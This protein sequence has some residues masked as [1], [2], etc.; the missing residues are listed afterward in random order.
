MTLTSPAP[1]HSR[2]GVLPGDGIG[3]EVTREAVRVLERVAKHADLQLT[4]TEGMLGGCAIEQTG[5]P[6]PAETWE[7]CKNSDALLVGAVGGEKWDSLPAEK[8]PGLGGLLRLRRELDLFANLRPGLSYLP[9]LSPLRDVNIDI[10]LVREAVGGLYF[11]PE[12]GRGVQ[13]GVETAWDTMHYTAEQVRRIGIVACRLASERG[14]RLAS[15]DKANVLESS[16]LWRE[17]M[18]EVVADFPHLEVEHL[19]VDNCAM[20][21]VHRP[22]DFDV[23]V[24]ENLFGDVLSDEIAGIVGSLGLLP[25]GSLRTDKFGLYEP[26]HGAAPDIAGLGKANPSAAILSAAMLLRHSLDRPEDA[27]VIE[28]AVTTVLQ[29]GI[30]TADLANGDIAPVSTSAF[31]DAVLAELDDQYHAAAVSATGHILST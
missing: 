30:R 29:R 17:V 27:A 8:N 26:V 2:I 24:T 31:G 12:R 9:E 6:L 18:R 14:G 13:D 19:Y 25:S 11:S 1:L 16:K 10:L 23:I 3:P 5:T 28:Q 20:Q 15:V 21:L 4:F 7:L 22:N